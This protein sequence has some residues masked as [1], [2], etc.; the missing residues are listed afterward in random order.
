M[1]SDQKRIKNLTTL[2][3]LSLYPCVVRGRSMLELQIQGNR[4]AEAAADAEKLALLNC[5][6][7]AA[8]A[9]A[10]HRTAPSSL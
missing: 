9:P 7:D 4:N 5:N 10:L 3:V 8:A 1:A 2:L 6:D